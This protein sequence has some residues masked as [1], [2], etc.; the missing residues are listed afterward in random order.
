MSDSRAYHLTSSAALANYF[1]SR[2][3]DLYVASC[4]VPTTV[5]G[6]KGHLLNTYLQFSI[7]AASDGIRLLGDNIM[8]LS[9]ILFYSR[10]NSE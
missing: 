5:P 3:Y 6:I 4:K 10:V 7:N 2:N 8:L 1:T 9:K